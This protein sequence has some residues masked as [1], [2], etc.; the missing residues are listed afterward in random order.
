MFFRRDKLEIGEVVGT[1][2]ELLYLAYVEGYTTQELADMTGRPRNT[3]LSQL[4]RARHK[5]RGALGD[6]TRKE[7]QS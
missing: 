2:R 3:V 4:H 1:E 5:L 7:A 6:D